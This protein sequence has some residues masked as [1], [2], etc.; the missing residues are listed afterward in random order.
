MRWVP[1]AILFR[2]DHVNGW[3]LLASN[4]IKLP[5]RYFQASA[6]VCEGLK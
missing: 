1:A 5:L 6:F 4:W 2:D 3:D